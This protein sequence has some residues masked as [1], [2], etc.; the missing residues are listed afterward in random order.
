VSEEV[1][2]LKPDPHIFRI[3]LERV[4][5]RAEDAVMVGDMWDIDILGARA[6][7][8]RAIWLNRFG[9]AN[10]DPAL[11]TKITSFEPVDDAL[12]A[13]LADAH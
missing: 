12:R 4:G 3:A 6:A 9:L 13:I 10:P 1:G 5:C 2:V 11:A 7:E 8:I